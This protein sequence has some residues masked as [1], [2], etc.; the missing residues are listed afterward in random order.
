M[1]ENKEKEMETPEVEAGSL[2]TDQESADDTDG[3]PRYQRAMARLAMRVGI[4]KNKKDPRNIV[5]AIMKKR[6]GQR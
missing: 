6:G 3:L 2:Q 4:I 1:S 5:P